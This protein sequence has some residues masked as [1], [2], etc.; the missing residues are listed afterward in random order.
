MGV[1]SYQSL[2]TILAKSKQER[3]HAPSQFGPQMVPEKAL[4]KTALGSD[5]SP[6]KYLN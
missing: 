3:R 5:Q 6:A 4:Q 2:Y 1:S